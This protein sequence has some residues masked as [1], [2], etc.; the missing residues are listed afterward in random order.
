MARRTREKLTLPAVEMRAQQTPETTP[1]VMEARWEAGEMITLVL[2]FQRWPNGPNEPGQIVRRNL[3]FPLAALLSNP[4]NFGR[5]VQGLIVQVKDGLN[6]E[7][8]KAELAALKAVDVPPTDEQLR[9]MAQM[10]E[11]LSGKG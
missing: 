10:E 4:A 3:V 6:I 8:M 9:V 7:T 5:D 11:A 1:L 2:E